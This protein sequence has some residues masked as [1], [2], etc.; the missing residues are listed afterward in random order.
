M[1]LLL[2]ILIAAASATAALADPPT[3]APSAVV[4]VTLRPA[5]AVRGTQAAVRDVA[6]LEGGSL[7]DR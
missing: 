3:W 1:R 2:P 7:A 5:A 4:V 6:S